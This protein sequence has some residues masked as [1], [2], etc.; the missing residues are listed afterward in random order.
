MHLKD[1]MALP[2]PKSPPSVND[3]GSDKIRKDVSVASPEEAL[4]C[5]QMF[6]EETEA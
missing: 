3:E 2:S 5:H 4:G 6:I 1:D